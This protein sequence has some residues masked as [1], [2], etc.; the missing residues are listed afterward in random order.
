MHMQ[1]VDQFLLYPTVPM[2][3]TMM[4]SI[5]RMVQEQR[6]CVI[7]DTPPVMQTSRAMVSGSSQLVTLLVRY[8]YSEIFRYT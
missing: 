5:H 3:C 6:L 8:H 2:S 1:T 7:Q 4:S